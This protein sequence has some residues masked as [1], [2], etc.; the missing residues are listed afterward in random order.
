MTYLQKRELLPFLVVLCRRINE[1]SNAAMKDH[2]LSF[3]ELSL[4][5]AYFL[6]TRRNSSQIKH[7]APML[8]A[9]SATLKAGKCQPA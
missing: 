5:L 2:M 1:Q 9:L 7:T 6:L 4:I 3:S 8:I